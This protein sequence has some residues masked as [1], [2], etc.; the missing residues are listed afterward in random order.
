MSLYTIYKLLSGGHTATS[1]TLIYIQNVLC[2]V[3]VVLSSVIPL[4]WKKIVCFILL[5][6]IMTGLTI[7]PLEKFY[8]W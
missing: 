2:M 4:K 3:G 7:N 8:N 1:Y 5:F 6:S